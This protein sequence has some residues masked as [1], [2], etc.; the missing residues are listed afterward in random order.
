MSTTINHAYRLLRR[1]DGRQYEKTTSLVTG[2]SSGLGAE[3]ARQLAARG[4][5][6]VLVARSADRLTALAEQ[7]QANHRVTVTTLPA[8]L[9]LSA[10]VS[11]IV[12]FTATTP[13]HILVNNAGFGTYGNFADLDA[14]REHT[15]VM[16][17]IAAAVALAHAVLPGMLAR[18]AGGIITVASTIAF[19]PSPL[20][21]V[22]G[23]TKAFDLA[24]SEALWAETLGSG[25]RIV[26]LCPGP[27]TTGFF[28]NLG[29]QR[30]TSSIIYRHTADPVSVVR[31]GLRGF[32]HDAMTV[33]PGL[34]NRF[35][36]QGHRFLPRPVMARIA[37]RMLS[38]RP[39]PSRDLP[40]EN[41]HGA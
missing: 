34:R 23:A 39:A 24:F 15:E 28:A 1:P 41:N 12:A 38:P 6:L 30:A 36:A 31:A 10:D 14:A 13:V 16:V 22:Y 7:L 25:V 35:L 9:S 21:A 26:A 19:Q 32:D 40:H 29:D 3:F 18:R 8:D 2:A 27:T 4:S 17:N 33:I 20:Q 37:G 11:R 5:D